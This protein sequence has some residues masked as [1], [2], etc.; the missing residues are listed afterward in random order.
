M[1]EQ[2]QI[3][4]KLAQP[5]SI[6]CIQDILESD[7]NL[8][9][10][11]LAERVCEHFGLFNARG[12]VQRAGCM[13]ALSE[14]ERAGHFMLP[15]R[16]A[17]PVVKTPRR[18]CAPVPAPQQVPDQVGDVRGLQLIRVERPDQM[19]V[20]NELMLTEHP[21]GS[22]SLVGNQL[23]YLIDSE[24][25]WLGGL[26]FSASALNLADRD[27]WIGWDASKRKA[28]LH[29]V[30]GMSRFLIRPSVRCH[31]LASQVLGM[32]LRGL[33]DDFE[34]RY[35][36][37]PWLVESFVDTEQY[38]GTCYQASNWIRV[39]Q[40]QGRGRQ[41]RGHERA[42]TIKAI[43]LYVLEP[44]LRA[45]LGVSEPAGLG[46]LT[47][48]EGL[49]GEV[50]ADNEFGGAVLGDR[51]LT[52]RLV[53]SARAQASKP[54][55]SFCAV[56][57]GDWAAA[58]GYYRLIDQADDAA[59]T[60][61]AIIAPH[62]QR[63]VQRMK[64]H[65]T[66]LCIQDGT[67]V[68]YSSLAQC[69]G[70]GVIGTNQTGATSR[71]LHL[72][73]T[74]AVSTE[75]L[76]L[77]VLGAQCWAPEPKSEDTRPVAQRPLEEK[78][79][80]CWVKGLRESNELARELPETRQVCVMDREADFFELFEQPRHRRVD[81]LVRAKHNRCTGGESKLF[82]TLRDSEVRRRLRIPVPR[83]SARPKKSKQKARA[84]QVGRIAEV[85]LR[86]QSIDLPAPGQHKDKPP[87]TLQ[88]VHVHE[89]SPPS[90]STRLEWFLLTTGEIES[91]EGAEQCLRWYCLRWRIEDWHR[92]LKSG[93]GI[94]ELAHQTAQRLKR[95]IGINLVIAWRIMLMT[96][97]GR[98]CP[99]LPAEILFSD[100][101]IEVLQAYAVKKN[102][103]AP[104]QLGEAVRLVAQIGGYLG[105]ANDPPP[106]HQ[107]M[108]EGLSQ[109][110]L[111]CEGFAL[112]GG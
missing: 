53:N 111:L 100:L 88:V 11:R 109:L 89:P 55:R 104:T 8:N 91:A 90:G 112:R 94:E 54:G 75:G 101:E 32:S 59:V 61:E 103:K 1:E 65:S 50:W 10:T 9:R 12:K 96:L 6:I 57:Q 39:G 29:R 3:K 82:D 93:C 62:R 4:R 78:K 30:V 83:K 37:R 64:A 21:L 108:W 47:I 76:P 69:E 73:S 84:G 106:G 56:V 79:S 68:N 74:L 52:D 70:L 27:R 35:G 16:R 81:L 80:F 51:R 34:A 49:E 58:K 63:T 77:G 7:D 110:G 46:A 48:D 36:Y 107:L 98:E 19:R 40:T 28:H 99:E 85:E 18:L 45:R 86:Y 33:G 60:L 26:G 22:V 15:S 67:D 24:H 23:R 13:K 71:G 66:V 41:D 42:K 2:S 38:A 44:A 31:N 95:A 102:C 105:R 72:H 17:E 14:L 97:L 92:V 25:G 87:I 20:W 43:Y 5:E